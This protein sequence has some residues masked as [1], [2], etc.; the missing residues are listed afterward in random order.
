MAIETKKKRINIIYVLLLIASFAFG[1]WFWAKSIST[2]SVA[3]S[4]VDSAGVGDGWFQFAILN[5]TLPLLFCLIAA[6]AIELPIILLQYVMPKVLRIFYKII[7]LAFVVLGTYGLITF[8]NETATG[9]GAKIFVGIIV[10]I[11]SIIFFAPTIIAVF[12]D[13]VEVMANVSIVTA[14]CF[15]LAIF[16]LT[17]AMWLMGAYPFLGL[18]LLLLVLALLGIDGYVVVRITVDIY[19]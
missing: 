14:I 19:Y 3:I 1:V 18:L 17:S 13:D 5:L 9:T 12:S 2:R 6:F 15:A 7:M 10:G 16:V 11:A 4:F 8:M